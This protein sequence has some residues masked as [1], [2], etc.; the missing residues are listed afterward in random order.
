VSGAAG[1]PPQ[2]QMPGMRWLWGPPRPGYEPPPQH[3]ADY[4]SLIDYSAVSQENLMND[5][6]IKS[7]EGTWV[8]RPE[9]LHDQ[10]LRMRAMELAVQFACSG[11]FNRMSTVVGDANTFYNF[12]KG[13][14]DG[15][16]NLHDQK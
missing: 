6:D 15:E 3:I 14:V 9:F 4:A 2:P 1:A 5:A 10:K 11:H 16:Q 13:E 7:L 8:M 12:L